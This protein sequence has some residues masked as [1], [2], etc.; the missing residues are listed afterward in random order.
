MP[1]CP[2]GLTHKGHSRRAGKPRKSRPTRKSRPNSKVNDWRCARKPHRSGGRPAAIAKGPAS[3]A[4]ISRGV[5]AC[6]I[7]VGARAYQRSETR[8]GTAYLRGLQWGRRRARPGRPTCSQPRA[9]S[10]LAVRRR[11]EDHADIARSDNV[12]AATIS[13]LLHTVHAAGI[14]RG[15][16]WRGL[17]HH[18]RLP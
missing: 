12:N 9:S 18:A 3:R 4:R 10:F 7:V 5:T 8:P 13:G 2:T 15:A 6:T 17:R 14:G 16:H 11:V 1:P